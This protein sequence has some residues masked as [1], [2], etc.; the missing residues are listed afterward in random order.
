MK[1]DHIAIAVKS[2]EQSSK[3]WK[4]LFGLPLKSII[5]VKHQKVKVAVFKVGDTKIE[6]V[7]PLS[8]DS[9]VARFLEKR[10]EGLHHICFEV[11]DIEETI[12]DLK[13]KG[14]K[15]ID[16]TPK[17]GAS[18]KKVVFLHPKAVHS[19]LIELCEL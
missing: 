1:F 9:P 7:E 10:G 14:A 12:R 3:V 2:I 4:D 6:L 8:D 17:R 18:A 11:K 19:V 13:N 16:E 15:F 5:E